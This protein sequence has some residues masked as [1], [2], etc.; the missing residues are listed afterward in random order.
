MADV[1]TFSEVRAGWRSS[2]LQLLDR[3][4]E[5]LQA[6]RTDTR[7]RRADWTPIEHISPAL[8]AAVLHAEDRRFL[9]HT[10]VDWLATGKAALTNLYR[11]RPR[12]ASTLT[13]QLVALLDAELRARGQRRDLGE[14]WRQMQ[15]A[16]AL[17]RRW[18]KGEVLEAY[19]NLLPM[20]GE[21]TGIDAA[22]RALFDKRPAGLSAAESLII[23][24]L[25]RSPNAAPEVVARRVCALGQDFPAPLPD[26]N[27]L[28]RLALNTLT[29]RL[30][31][32]PAADLAPHVARRLATATTAVG[33]H[34]SAGDARLRTTLDAGLQRAVRDILHDQLL[35]LSARNVQDAAALVV[36]N[37]SGEVL[38]YAS[39]SAAGSASPHSD[40]VQAPRQAGSSLKP[41]LYALLLER[42][43]LTAASLLEDRPLTL[44]TAGGQYVPRNYDSDHK[45]WV[46]LR[47]ALAGSLNVPAVRALQLAGLEPFATLLAKLGFAGMTEAA[48]FYGPSMALGS[49]DVRLWELVN[50]Y[51]TLANGGLLTPLR[52][53]PERATGEHGTATRLFSSEAA[54]LVGDILSDR[55][56]RALTFGLENP[57]ATRYWTAVKTGTSKDMRD[58]WCVGWSTRYTVGVWV[59]NHD[60]APMHGVSG[61]SGAAPA[62]AA[63]MDRL[64]DGLDSRPPRPPRGLV[65]MRL[66]AAH[67]EPP[68]QEWFLRGTEPDTGRWQPALPRPAILTPADGAVYAIDPDI[69]A[70]SR[71]LRFQ[72]GNAPAGSRW[73]L[74][75]ELRAAEDWSP[76][77]GPHRI[78]LVDPVGHVLAEARFEVR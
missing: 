54:W 33:K 46:S 58:N 74:D 31:I 78:E 3:H 42:R 77:P 73:R 17:E 34:P 10:G 63:I 7:G 12:G 37:A 57:L 76:T 56:A 13:M 35:R 20:R 2:E 38:A 25:I 53:L 15:A 66:E 49:L 55:Q 18:T 71:L 8:V 24:A 75:D 68:R 72:A 50:A 5:L 16:R 11:E 1:P 51:R 29:G 70:A 21:L 41:L 30:P 59:G 22:A 52:L 36:D 23:A 28:R 40:G 48:D 62:W 39:L 26:C 14:K 6:L 60:G 44:V 27:A 32:L 19:L 61:V 65:R 47:A 64:H 9:R 43:I 69:P 45:G 4:G 67:G